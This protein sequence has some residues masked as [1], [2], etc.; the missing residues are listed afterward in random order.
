MIER[1]I[2][3][4]MMRARYDPL[5]DHE[6]YF[7]SI[8][9]FSGLWAEG[10]TLDECRSDL[11]SALEGWLQVSLEQRLEIPALDGIEFGFSRSRTAGPL[12][13]LAGTPPAHRDN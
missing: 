6:G 11:R 8:P 2:D 13:F 4:A 3:A 10:M 1:Y 12:R 7:G 9:G 5:E